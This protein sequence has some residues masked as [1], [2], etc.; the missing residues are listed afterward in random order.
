MLGHGT[1][2][3][4]I[5]RAQ[6]TLLLPLAGSELLERFA[7]FGMQGVLFL[8]LREQFSNGGGEGAW[9][10]TAL[11]ALLGQA[12]DSSGPHLASALFGL[13]TGLIYL[14][15]IVGGWLADR[16]LGARAATCC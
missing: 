1:G 5:V 11:K 4:R 13:V 15:T 3:G 7:F 12:S 8:Y 2:D 10:L 6:P 14:F 9:G 16:R